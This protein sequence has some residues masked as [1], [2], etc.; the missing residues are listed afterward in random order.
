MRVELI[1]DQEDL[2]VCVV[3]V[4]N[5]NAITG[6]DTQNVQ[7]TVHRVLNHLNVA[8]GQVVVIH[9]RVSCLTSQHFATCFQVHVKEMVFLQHPLSESSTVDHCI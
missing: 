9:K 1:A 4:L 8:L 3:L 7:H 5:I 6:N 2:N